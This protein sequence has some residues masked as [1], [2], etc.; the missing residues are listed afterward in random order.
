MS[1][2]LCVLP[3]GQRMEAGKGKSLQGEGALSAKGR[4][5]MRGEREGWKNSPVELMV[6]HC[7]RQ[8]PRSAALHRSWGVTR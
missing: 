7:K 1:T 5:Q 8:W 4:Q 6:W 3:L 2:V